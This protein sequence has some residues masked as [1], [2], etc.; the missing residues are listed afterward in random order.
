VL[1]TI[2]WKTLKKSQKTVDIIRTLTYNEYKNRG[3][4]TRSKGK[5]KMKRLTY[6]ESEME[7][8][9]K[10]TTKGEITIKKTSPNKK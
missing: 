2:L 5:N 3:T 8:T 6:E 7:I 9:I 1:Y 10:I 4:L